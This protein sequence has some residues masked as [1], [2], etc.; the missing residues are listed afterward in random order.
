M[1]EKIHATEKE[2]NERVYR[3]LKRKISEL[4]VEDRAERKAQFLNGIREGIANLFNKESEQNIETKLLYRKKTTDKKTE[5]KKE[6]I[7]KGIS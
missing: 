3:K 7:K 2:I 6:K 5:N 4:D 1:Q